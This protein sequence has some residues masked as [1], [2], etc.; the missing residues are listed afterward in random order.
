MTDRLIGEGRAVFYAF[1]LTLFRIIYRIE[2]LIST[3]LF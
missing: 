2:G 3:H 1:L